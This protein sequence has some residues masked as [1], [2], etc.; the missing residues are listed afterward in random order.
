M[1][2]DYKEVLWGPRAFLLGIILVLGLPGLV[3]ISMLGD[4]MIEAFLPYIAALL[5]FIVPYYLS[6]NYP[7]IAGG[8]LIL[9]GLIPILYFLVK[10]L[11]TFPINFESIILT[12]LIIIPL[13]IPVSIGM[14]MILAIRKIQT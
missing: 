5:P 9:E 14:W 13:L 11:S 3:I 1:K 6:L 7:K 12:S 8:L 2:K 4:H 10:L